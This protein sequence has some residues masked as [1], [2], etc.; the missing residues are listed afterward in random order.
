MDFFQKTEILCAMEHFLN[1]NL[2]QE[3]WDNPYTKEESI[4]ILKKF[5]LDMGYC[6]EYVDELFYNHIFDLSLI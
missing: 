5:Y 2:A 3:S 4:A 1:P 6:E